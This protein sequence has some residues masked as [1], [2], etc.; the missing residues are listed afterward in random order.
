MPSPDYGMAAEMAGHLTEI[1]SQ[2]V[3]DAV[4]VAQKGKEVKVGKKNV[5]GRPAPD[6]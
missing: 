1:L 2:L 4:K 5:K 3:A 6:K